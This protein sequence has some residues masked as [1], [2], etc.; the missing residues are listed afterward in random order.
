MSAPY[1]VVE[2]VV[3]LQSDSPATA[4]NAEQLQDIADGAVCETT[5][6]KL[7]AKRNDRITVR[8][9]AT[10]GIAVVA[11]LWQVRSLKERLR[12]RLHGSKG[13]REYHA[14][15]LMYDQGLAVPQVYGFVKGDRFG[16]FDECVISEYIEN[17]T[18]LLQLLHTAINVGDAN[19]VNNLSSQ[20]NKL[21]RKC[22]AANIVDSDHR[23]GNFIVDPHDQVYRIDLENARILKFS[24]PDRCLC[25]MLGALITSYA[26]A[27]RKAPGTGDMLAARLLES[28][29]VDSQL[30]RRVLERAAKETRALAIRTGV[31]TPFGMGSSS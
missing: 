21:T 11:K 6:V 8:L 31:P 24:P 2:P 15:R 29:E 22:I 18:G 1:D 4:F 20:A 12:R 23:L 16:M 28:C 17:S 7:L 26:W 13:T 10:S 14:S 27:A 19:R 5:S 9:Q 30:A 3:S 25:R